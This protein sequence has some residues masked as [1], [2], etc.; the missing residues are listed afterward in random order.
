MKSWRGKYIN[1][2][3]LTDEMRHKKSINI[4]VS[5]ML[6]LSIAAQESAH[7]FFMISV[8]PIKSRPLKP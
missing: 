1:P 3:K 2:P 7:F 5:K 6:A 8:A 4:R